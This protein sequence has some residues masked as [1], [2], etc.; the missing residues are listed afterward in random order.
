MQSDKANQSR[1]NL[2][3]L[4]RE[5]PNIAKAFRETL[6]EMSKPENVEKMAREL[7]QGINAIN[8]IFKSRKGLK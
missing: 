1:E 7:T 8:A 6:D 3:K 5:N 2:K 4:L